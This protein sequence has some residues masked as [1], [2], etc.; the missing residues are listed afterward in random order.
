[1]MTADQHNGGVVDVFDLATASG[2]VVDQRCAAWQLHCGLDG[3]SFQLRRPSGTIVTDPPTT[4]SADQAGFLIA[5][6][7][8]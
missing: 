4:I 1:M 2:T 5:P 8:A 3:L 7:H 6:R